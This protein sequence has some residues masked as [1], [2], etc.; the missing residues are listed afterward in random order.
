MEEPYDKDQKVEEILSDTDVDSDDDQSD[1][2][3]SDASVKSHETRKN[4]SLLKKLFEQWH[5]LAIADI[6]DSKRKCHCPACQKLHRALNPYVGLQ[7][8]MSH[9]KTLLSTRRRIY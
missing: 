6:N 2:S 5:S 3:D 7:G 8:L 1:E 9:V 4:H